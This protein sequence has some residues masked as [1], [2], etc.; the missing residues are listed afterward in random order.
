MSRNDRV[1]YDMQATPREQRALL[2]AIWMRATQGDDIVLNDSS[3]TSSDE[4]R[5]KLR[6]GDR[7]DALRARL[8]R[9]N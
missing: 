5:D 4:L 1:S 7:G 8:A 3:T 6:S 2:S 9:T